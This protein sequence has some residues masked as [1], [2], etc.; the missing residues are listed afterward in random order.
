MVNPLMSNFWAFE[1]LSETWSSTSSCTILG[2]PTE[3][4]PSHQLDRIPWRPFGPL[5]AD[6]PCVMPTSRLFYSDFPFRSPIRYFIARRLFYY[7][8]MGFMRLPQA[9]HA[10]RPLRDDGYHYLPFS[11]YWVCHKIFNNDG[12]LLPSSCPSHSWINPW[13]AGSGVR[14]TC[15]ARWAAGMVWLEIWLVLT[16]RAGGFEQETHQDIVKTW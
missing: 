11:S 4:G 2:W 16:P 15:S 7:P 13:L 12:R 3:K 8:P 9:K 1:F 5:E 14:R 6:V 10:N